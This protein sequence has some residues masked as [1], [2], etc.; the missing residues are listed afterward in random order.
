MG[1]PAQAEA[2]GRGGRVRGRCRASFAEPD[3]GVPGAGL[4][5][6]RR[7]CDRAGICP[8]ALANRAA[9]VTMTVALRPWSLPGA[10]RTPD[11]PVS[12]DGR[13]PGPGRAR[14][15]GPGVRSSRAGWPGGKVP[16]AG[17]LAG[18]TV[19]TPRRVP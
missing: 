13:V 6:R 2:A 12:E 9:G 16:A 18:R 5:A 15:G 11:G 3:A 8:R 1:H 7:R 10:G 4:G 17:Q 14:A 19:Y